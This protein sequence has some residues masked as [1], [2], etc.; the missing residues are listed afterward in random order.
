MKPQPKQKL[1]R[2]VEE[3]DIAAEQEAES[4]LTSESVT[5]EYSAIIGYQ[6]REDVKSL[7]DLIYA[8]W[9][10]QDSIREDEIGLKADIYFWRGMAVL[11]GCMGWG[12]VLTFSPALDIHQ[13]IMGGLAVV[14]A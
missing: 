2:L 8:R 5:L 1:E 3:Q 11:G 10:L 4:K 13:V 12:S 7:T 6:E 14:V 9:L